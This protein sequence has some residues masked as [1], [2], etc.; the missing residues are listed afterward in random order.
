[1]NSV[2]NFMEVNKNESAKETAIDSSIKGNII[3]NIYSLRN[4]FLII[5]LTGRTGSGCTSVASI[6]QEE[7]VQNMKSNYSKF[8]SGAIDNQARKDRIVYNFI[9]ENWKKFEVITAS[10]II[11]YF[12]LLLDY[13]DFIGCITITLRD[14]KNKS[15]TESTNK[16]KEEVRKKLKDVESKF[17]VLHDK[18]VEINK[19]IEEGFHNLADNDLIVYKKYF[20]SDLKEFR[21]EVED[22]LSE[23]GRGF[24]SRLLQVWGNNIRSNSSVKSFPNVKAST[25]D[26]IAKIINGII[27]IIR[28]LNKRNKET[29]RI[30]IDALRNP[31]EILYFRER[32]SAFYCMSVNTERTIRHDKLFNYKK[33][34]R[35]EID[36]IDAVEGEKKDLNKS[37]IE[38]DIDKCIELSDIHL[39]HD[40][41]PKNRNTNLINQIF[42]YLSL[43][44]HPGLIPPTPSNE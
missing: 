11:Y 40:G 14:A 7:D 3:E 32:Y 24:V 34:T 35:D 16:T 33:L 44:L 17:H 25:P 27:K 10:N 38:I 18:A 43:M 37:F 4:N 29:T 26:A 31:F 6:L 21:K 8:R 12:S 28:E 20:Q 2:S 39:S 13:E 36:H 41:T 1:M 5:G 22:A 23:Y 15:E 42:T 19:Y 30:A 9:T